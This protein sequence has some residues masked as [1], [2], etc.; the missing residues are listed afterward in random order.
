MCIRDRWIVNLE[1]HAKLASDR[2]AELQSESKLFQATLAEVRD[3][4]PRVAQQ[5]KVESRALVDGPIDMPDLFDASTFL[6]NE[7]GREGIVRICFG[8]SRA[9]R[10]GAADQI[11]RYSKRRK[12]N[13]GHGVAA[14]SATSAAA[15]TA[16]K[17]ASEKP[18]KE[19]LKDS[20]KPLLAHLQKDKSPVEHIVAWARRPQDDLERVQFY[21]VQGRCI[22]MGGEVAQGPKRP[23]GRPRA[24][25]RRSAPLP[26]G[27]QGGAWPR[28]LAAPCRPGPHRCQ[29]LSQ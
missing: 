17:Q 6:G 10:R 16:T 18:K 14:S 13:E 20:A 19:I 23:I 27:A 2:R 26:P 5:P 28:R 4:E 21:C 24:L 3:S 12:D 29:P 8:Q 7:S 15:A 25:M 22:V 1:G 11:K 9:I